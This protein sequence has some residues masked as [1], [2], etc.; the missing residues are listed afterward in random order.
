[1]HHYIHVGRSPTA[2]RK[3]LDDQDVVLVQLGLNFGP[4][5]T[6]GLFVNRVWFEPWAS[7]E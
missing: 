1:L 6:Q 7:I 3:E 4:M 2:S 5:S